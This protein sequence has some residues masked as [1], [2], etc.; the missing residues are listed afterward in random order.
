MK[1]TMI[2]ILAGALTFAAQPGVAQSQSPDEQQEK[3]PKNSKAHEPESQA[4]PPNSGPS[5][6]TEQGGNNGT[7]STKK[8]KK[9]KNNARQAHGTPQPKSTKS[10]QP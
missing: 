2:V 6:D 1:T 9:N 5:P 4:V 7:A 8:T 3:A 10:P